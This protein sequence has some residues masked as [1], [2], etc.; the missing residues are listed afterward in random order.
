MDVASVANTI[1]QAD[2]WNECSLVECR[3]DQA[4]LT[5]SL[6]ERPHHWNSS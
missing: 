6:A 1:P 4:S 2:P 3:A 5:L